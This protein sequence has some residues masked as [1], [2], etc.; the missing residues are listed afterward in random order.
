MITIYLIHTRSA[1]LTVRSNTFID[2]VW[3]VNPC[4]TWFTSAGVRI[5][6]IYTSTLILAWINK[7]VIDIQFTK[8]TVVPCFTNTLKPTH[9]IYTNSWVPTWTAGAFIG[10]CFAIWTGVSSSTSASKPLWQTDARRTMSTAIMIAM[11]CTSSWYY[12]WTVF[13]S[14]SCSTITAIII[15]EVCT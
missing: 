9:S 2:I 3:A 11:I 5:H 15:I 10:I 12:Y 1:I 8:S 7:A 6:S 14:P 4:V 13:P